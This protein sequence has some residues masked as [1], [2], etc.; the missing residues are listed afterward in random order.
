MTL[1]L[2]LVRYGYFQSNQLQT[3]MKQ[4]DNWSKRTVNKYQLILFKMRIS[5][6]P[7]NTVFGAWSDWDFGVILKKETEIALRVPNTYASRIS[8]TR[9]KF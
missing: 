9:C 7:E 2:L 8:V 5:T 4:F 3:V 6:K 1:L